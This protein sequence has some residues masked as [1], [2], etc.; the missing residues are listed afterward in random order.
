MYVLDKQIELGG[1]VLYAEIEFN[2]LPI[3]P[4]TLTDPEE[5]GEVDLLGVYVALAEGETYDVPRRRMNGWE[6]DLD[7]LA[8]DWVREHLDIQELHDHANKPE[9]SNV[10]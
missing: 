6:R 1:M 2:R 8:L 4:A 3:T 9:D 10:W 5:G 7:R